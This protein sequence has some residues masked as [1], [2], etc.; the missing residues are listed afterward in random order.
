[1]TDRKPL[2]VKELVLTAL[3]TALIIVG[4][5]L[6]F[7]FPGGVPFTMANF[8]VILAGLVIGPWWGLASVCLFLALG[9]VGLPVFS[10]ALVGLAAFQGPTG[11]F[12]IG[13]LL[14]VLLSGLIS[15]RSL[16]AN[17]HEGFLPFLRIVI[18]SL[19]GA[20]AV[21][22]IGLPWLALVLSPKYSSY[23]DALMNVPVFAALPFL[24]PD[25]IKVIIAIILAP[26]MRRLV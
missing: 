10:A 5:K 26:L 24:I 18:A 22:I 6:S 4:A 13:Y 23:L 14:A 20:L 19:I 8:F 1:M 11:G 3:F 7:A 2:P 9:L 21:Y 15:G 25:G 12:L 17:K 16:G